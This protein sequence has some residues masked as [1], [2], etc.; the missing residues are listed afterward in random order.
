MLFR[1]GREPAIRCSMAT[2]AQSL[3]GGWRAGRLYVW[4]G[5]PSF[6]KTSFAIGEMLEAC[7]Q[8]KRAAF[9]SLEMPSEQLN[10]RVLSYISRVPM[11][12]MG[13][14]TQQ[15][16]IAL[17]D[18]ASVASELDY[19][20]LDMPGRKIGNIVEALSREHEQRPLGFVVI[21]YLQ[22]I[23]PEDSKTSREQQV[24]AMSR[25]LKLMALTFKVPVILLSQLNRDSEKND[26][27]PRMSEI[28]RAHV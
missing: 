25:R 14:P 18:A 26:R 7:Y 22:L 16:I 3:S 11:V 24:A 12:N 13:A 23:S 5:P 8:G 1:S 9:V 19:T 10:S 21:D 2:L 20:V 28:G 27:R 17:R 4:A 6:G 15:E